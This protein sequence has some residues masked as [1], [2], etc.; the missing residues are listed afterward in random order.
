MAFG[1]KN[2]LQNIFKDFLIIFWFKK[3]PGK[4]LNVQFKIK[5]KQSSLTTNKNETKNVFSFLSL[6]KSK[7]NSCHLKLL[8]R[9]V[10]EG[11]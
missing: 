11:I 1:P 2:Y 9:V 6:I 3:K 4:A 5:L 8:N 7:L 10:V